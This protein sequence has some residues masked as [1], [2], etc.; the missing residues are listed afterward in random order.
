PIGRVCEFERMVRNQQRGALDELSARAPI[1]LSLSVLRTLLGRLAR[2]FEACIADVEERV[3]A[4][5][6]YS[7]FHVPTVILHGVLPYVSPASYPFPSYQRQTRFP[8]SFLCSDI[9]VARLDAID[10]ALAQP[11]KQGVAALFALKA[12]PL[13]ERSSLEPEGGL[14]SL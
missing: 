10:D 13:V 14:G 2:E 5:K 6:M 3:N 4:T 1:E 7:F 8:S 9:S 11:G 12:D